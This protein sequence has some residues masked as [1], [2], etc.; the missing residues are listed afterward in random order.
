LT[1]SI[2]RRFQAMRRG[3]ER[4]FTMIEVIVSSGIFMVVIS[5]AIV[6]IVNAQRAS[7]AAQQRVDA[8]NI[9][10]FIIAKAR[11]D[12]NAGKINGQGGLQFPS[13]TGAGIASKSAMETFTVSRY[14]QFAAPLTTQCSPGTLF[15]IAVKVYQGQITITD[16]NK[17]K[18]LAQ[19]RSVV[20]CPPA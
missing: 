7:H 5:A 17:G 4:G 8:A 13:A 1:T 12:A 19:S 6:A 20:A 14:I 2:R 10:Q 11:A 15:T 16:A 3:S 18:Y 9:A